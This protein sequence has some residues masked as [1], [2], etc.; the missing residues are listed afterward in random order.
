MIS[1]IAM[2]IAFSSLYRLFQIPKRSTPHMPHIP[3]TAQ[4]I[5]RWLIEFLDDI[6]ITSFAD[7]LQLNHP[8]S[9]AFIYYFTLTNSKYTSEIQPI[10]DMAINTQVFSAYAQAILNPPAH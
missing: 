8:T 6:V 1:R 10:I 2:E 4:Q 9:A 7:D 3:I 5:K